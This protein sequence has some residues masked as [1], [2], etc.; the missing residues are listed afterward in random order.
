VYFVISVPLK[1]RRCGLFVACGF[2]PR[3]QPVDAVFWDLAPLID[4][5]LVTPF[6]FIKEASFLFDGTDVITQVSSEVHRY[7]VSRRILLESK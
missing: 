7:L 1:N 5:T 6:K 2:D 4:F 3:E